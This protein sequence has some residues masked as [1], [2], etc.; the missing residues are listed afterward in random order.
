MARNEQNLVPNSERTPE[1]RKANARKAGQAS[2]AARRRKKTF[3][4]MVEAALSAKGTMG[5]TVGDDVV[6]S[7]IEA[8]LAG[9]VKAAAWLRDTRGEKPVEKAQS[10]VEGT[11]SIS[12]DV[13]A[14][15]RREASEE[16]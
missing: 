7:M 13:G 10:S 14:A 1:E 8:C 5:E 4:E 15:A 16:L 2:G 12:W 6:L 3:R 11:L 9:D